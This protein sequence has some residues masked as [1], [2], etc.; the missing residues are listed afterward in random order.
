[1]AA[2]GALLLILAAQDA[3][4]ARLLA[5]AVDAK[6]PAERVKAAAALAA[7][8][9][10]TLDAWLAAAKGFGSFE[11]L[12]PGVKKETV[13]LWNGEMSSPYEVYLTIPK[14]YDPVKP[15]P[16]MLALHGAGGA[17]DEVHPW[18]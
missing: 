7:R 5:G 8:K 11:K 3:D 4:P 9:D 18:W 2:L 17:G 1:M 16:L 13:E 12:E 14:G 6:S 10:V 15:A